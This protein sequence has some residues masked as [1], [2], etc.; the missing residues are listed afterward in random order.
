MIFRVQPKII[1]TVT[2]LL[3]PGIAASAAE[4]VDPYAEPPPR[5]LRQFA[6][7]GVKI[8]VLERFDAAG[9][10]AARTVERLTSDVIIDGPIERALA[11][12]RIRL[13][14]LNP[15]PS[16]SVVYNRIQVW[17]CADAAKDYAGVVYNR[18]AS[19]VLCKTLVLD[20][21]RDRALPASCFLLVGGEG[22]P[23][24]TVYDDDSMVYLGLAAIARTPD[25]RSRRQDL[26]ASQALSRSMGFQNAD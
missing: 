9:N 11:G 15:C 18:R 13:R 12:W 14:G 7:E 21:D 1:A 4:G 5:Y 20:E 17:R 16:E 23:L 25:G 26:E 6:V 10:L 22:E 2:L 8:F 24:R 3:G 19:V